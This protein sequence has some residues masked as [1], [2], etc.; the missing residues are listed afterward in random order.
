MGS[1]MCIRD[2]CN[3]INIMRLNQGDVYRLITACNLYK[4]NTS[5]EYMWDEY[6][7]LIKKLEQ[8]CE[9]GNCNISK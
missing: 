5:S 7:H 3:T 4:E 9:Q 8:L 1:E 6:D 2:S